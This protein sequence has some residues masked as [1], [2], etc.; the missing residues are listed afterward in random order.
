MFFYD[1]GYAASEML[2]ICSGLNL[3][4]SKMLVH[5][6][7]GTLAWLKTVLNIVSFVLRVEI[8]RQSSYSDC[9]LRIK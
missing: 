7:L 3:G 9:R 6:P 4:K 5:G 1:F 8:S 2:N